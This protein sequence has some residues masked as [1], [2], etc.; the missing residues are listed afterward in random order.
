VRVLLDTVTFVRVYESGLRPLP[1]KARRA[2]QESQLFLSTISLVEIAIKCTLSRSLHFPHEAVQEAIHDM[3]L[4]VLSYT[5]A[6]AH[7][8]FAL[9]LVEDHRDPFDRML[10]AAAIEEELPIVTSDR[11][12]SRYRS[13]QVIWR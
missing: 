6:Q 13:L 4:T 3:R 1:V 7:R 5:P 2:L 9:P 11:Q 10:I 8:L 12:F